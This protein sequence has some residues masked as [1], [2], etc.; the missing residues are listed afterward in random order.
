[1]SKRKELNK[2]RTLPHLGKPSP[3]GEVER[4]TGVDLEY[5]DVRQVPS[6][7]RAA[8]VVRDHDVLYGTQIGTLHIEDIDLG[9]LEVVPVIQNG[10]NT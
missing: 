10:S 2:H 7:T 3:G 9:A 1:L 5:I 8:V 6:R 4:L